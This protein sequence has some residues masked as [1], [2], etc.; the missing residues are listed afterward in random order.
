MKTHTK[1]FRVSLNF[2]DSRGYKWGQSIPLWTHSLESALDAGR[3]YMNYM[4]A[5]SNG[6]I[7]T[8]Y[9]AHEMMEG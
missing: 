5:K 9:N 4:N 7:I 1:K 6:E 3:Q 2:Q 8:G